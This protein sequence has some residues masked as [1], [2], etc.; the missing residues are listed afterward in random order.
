MTT[1][2]T[3][4][5]QEESGY[6]NLDFSK[7]V[8]SE[9][10]GIEVKFTAFDVDWV[11]R[12]WGRKRIQMVETKVK[13]HEFSVGLSEGQQNYLPELAKIME[14]G[15]KAGAP[16]KGW[17]WHGF[18]LLQFQYTDPTKGSIWWDGRLVDEY[19]LLQ[20]CEMRT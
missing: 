20:L 13:Q 5:R 12:D 11:F 19:E 8:R 17:E 1:K 9:C 6:R 14:A 18:H 16:C 3:S 10:A 15:I 4:T 2:K 7:W